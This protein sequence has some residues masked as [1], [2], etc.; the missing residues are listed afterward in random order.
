MQAKTKTAK[1]SC[2]FAR[3]KSFSTCEEPCGAKVPTEP[4]GVDVWDVIGEK[5]QFGT[6]GKWEY[7]PIKDVKVKHALASAVGKNIIQ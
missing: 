5:W 6:I 7:F 3:N 2:T 4:Q 1:A